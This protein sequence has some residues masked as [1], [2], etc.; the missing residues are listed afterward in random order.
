MPGD[1]FT[2]QAKPFTME[3]VFYL[4]VVIQLT[5]LGKSTNGSEMKQNIS[6]DP[7]LRVSSESEYH[8]WYKVFHEEADFITITLNIV[9][10]V[11]ETSIKLFNGTPNH[12]LAIPPYNKWTWANEKGLHILQMDYRFK[13]LSLGTLIPS[14]HEVVFNIK[15]SDP[16]CFRKLNN[17]EKFRQIYQT[18]K[19]TLY[20]NN[21]CSELI[22]DSSYLCHR[23]DCKASHCL[24]NRCYKFNMDHELDSAMKFCDTDMSTVTTHMYVWL[25]VWF[26]LFNYSPMMIYWLISKDDLD[27]SFG[28]HHG[29]K[30]TYEKKQESDNKNNQ[31]DSNLEEYIPLFLICAENRKYYPFVSKI[32]FYLFR[33][34]LRVL[35]IARGVLACVILHFHVL[36]LVCANFIIY[37]FEFEERGKLKDKSLWAIEQ[38]VVEVEDSEVM[39]KLWS[40]LSF[41]FAFLGVLTFCLIIIV[42]YGK[43]KRHWFYCNRFFWFKLDEKLITPYVTGR[44]GSYNYLSYNLLERRL[45][46][47]QPEFWKCLAEKVTPKVLWVPTASPM[48]RES[49]LYPMSGL[50]YMCFIIY[51]ISVTLVVSLVTS[52][53]LICPLLD[54]L[55]HIPWN[56]EAVCENK[57]NKEM[58]TITEQKNEEAAQT[59][60]T[61][62]QDDGQTA[63]STNTDG[64]DDGQTAQSISTDGK[65]D[66]QTAQSTNTDGKDDGQTAQSTNTD[67][68][69]DGQ[70]AQTANERFN[71]CKKMWKTDFESVNEKPKEWETGLKIFKTLMLILFAVTFTVSYI[72]PTAKI[73]SLI[74]SYAIT[75]ILKNYTSLLPLLMLMTFIISKVIKVC[76]SAAEPFVNLQ[77]AIFNEYQAKIEAE[78]T[79]A[80]RETES[81]Q[82]KIEVESPQDKIKSTDRLIILKDGDYLIK[83]KF[84]IH[85][86]KPLL[87]RPKIYTFIALAKI[88]AL[89]TAGVVVWICLSVLEYNTLG[90]ILLTGFVGYLPQIFESIRKP[91]NEQK[92]KILLEKKLKERVQ[93][94]IENENDPLILL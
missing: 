34:D 72:Y 21:S 8:L 67:G 85:E 5:C 31:S 54:L 83:K 1:N 46:L 53:V 14:V 7:H 32:G 59:T 15:I 35:K 89:I 82:T 40:T 42:R 88:V 30:T 76:N 92:N 70:T 51:V 60:N 38:I 49:W 71:C 52:V 10:D 23:C 6:C 28:T 91:W 86:C 58:H 37:S 4:L 80:K 36:W 69:D 17:S 90:Q 18:F 24:A 48:S 50:I 63:Q 25:V 66:G 16:N 22:E 45:L 9:S 12:L 19:K 41:I 93:K 94:E 62:G 33:H 79:R 74:V 27:H 73:Y 43:I 44:K 87:C 77:F 75:G 68:K 26:I 13:M 55:L 29:S 84:I 56:E 3:F 57:S 78:S 39:V 2:C 64:I 20:K 81:S 47:V 61:G 65:D 11:N